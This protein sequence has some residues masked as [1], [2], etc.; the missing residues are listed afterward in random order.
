[1]V[2]QNWTQLSIHT[3]NGIMSFHKK[4]NKENILYTDMESSPRYIL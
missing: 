2:L 4:K 1:M 3:Y